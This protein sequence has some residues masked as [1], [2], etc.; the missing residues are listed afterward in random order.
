MIH[1]LEGNVLEVNETWLRM[2]KVTVEEALSYTVQDFSA[3]DGTM[4]ERLAG[5]GSFEPR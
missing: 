3:P 5:N 4:G 2:Y 1:D